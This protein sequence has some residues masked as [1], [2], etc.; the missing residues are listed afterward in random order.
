MKRR[1]LALVLALGLLLPA[2][3]GAAQAPDAAEAPPAPPETAT[4]G[5]FLQTLA[6]N[7]GEDVSD[8]AWIDMEE[9]YT[10]GA[11]VSDEVKWAF[12]KWILNGDGNGESLGTLRL[13]DPI[14][15]Q[16]AAAF[17]GRYLDYRY[18]ALPAGCGTGSPAGYN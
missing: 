9:Y 6:L 5:W 7:A 4:R 11:D 12:D 15:R 17:L 13:D 2:G 18:T 1:L 16:E 3:A 8:S 10:D 14:T